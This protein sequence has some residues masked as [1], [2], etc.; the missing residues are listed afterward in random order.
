VQEPAAHGATQL[1]VGR[2][3]PPPL[4]ACPPSAPRRLSGA[5]VVSSRRLSMA[6]PSG[7]CSPSFRFPSARF[8]EDEVDE[9]GELELN[10]EEFAA[11]EQAHV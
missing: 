8:E 10:D 2:L 1:L 3:A 7:E 6:A 5:F 11:R 4:T 9:M